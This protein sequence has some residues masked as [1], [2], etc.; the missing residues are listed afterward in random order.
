[1]K[2]LTRRQREFLGKFLDLYSE[3]RE[4][5]H[6][7]VV[8]ERLGVGNVSAYEMLRLLEERGLVK[9]EYQV[10]AERRGPGRAPVVFAPTPL[11]MQE[12]TRL[13]GGETSLQ[14]WETARARILGRIEAGHAEGYATLL[15]E[16][17]ARMP[18]QRS[19]LI[20]GAE[21][22]TAI[23][24]GLKSLRDSAE[25]R[26][27][28]KRLKSIGKPGE[29]GLSALAGLSMGLSMVERINRR[30]AGFL[31]AQSGR[32]H[33]I[34]AQLNDES[35]RQLTEFMQEAMRLAGM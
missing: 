6:Y 7:T 10:P 11:A 17:L 20:Y 9:A 26:R 30:L 13:S 3:G 21:M 28:E 24:L 25:A 14:E 1:M 12:L 34:L 18:E 2:E 16:L 33:S 8:A 27:L 23:V 31:L 5:L 35:R 4:S 15:A 32:F 29:L 19:P 22:I